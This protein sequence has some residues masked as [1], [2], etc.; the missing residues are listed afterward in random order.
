MM[1]LLVAGIIPLLATAGSNGFRFLQ[2]TQAQQ[3][4]KGAFIELHLDPILQEGLWTQVQWR[5]AFGEW[6]NT[7]GWGGTLIEKE[8]LVRWYLGEELLDTGP[9]R[10]QIFERNTYT[11][12]GDPSD[13]GKL[14][15]TNKLLASSQPF[16]LP[17]DPGQTLDIEVEMP[18]GE[19]TGPIVAQ[20]APAESVRYVVKEG[21][22]LARIAVRFNSSVKAIAE[23]NKIKDID[24][25]FVGQVLAIPRN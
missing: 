10:W 20:S 22:T 7:D 6:H 1:V 14:V 18:A 19:T 13:G 17:E 15:A 5:D 3:E 8:Q 2:A 11:L 4:I 23:V 25:I 9:Y 21:D 24:L 12:S 16:Y